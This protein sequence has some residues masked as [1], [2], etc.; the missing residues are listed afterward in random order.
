MLTFI[1]MSQTS[2]KA[3][4][5]VGN[6]EKRRDVGG[7]DDLSMAIERLG[8]CRSI[9]NDQFWMANSQLTPAASESLRNGFLSKGRWQYRK[10]FCSD[11]KGICEATL[12]GYRAHR[13]MPKTNWRQITA[14]IAPNSSLKKSA[15]ANRQAPESAHI[16]GPKKAFLWAARPL[17]LCCFGHVAASEEEGFWPALLCGVAR[18]AALAASAPG[19]DAEGAPPPVPREFRGFGLPLSI[20]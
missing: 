2:R 15:H 19:A 5:G 20:I 13:N 1:E 18:C 10:L 11:P 6:R 3:L 9:P 17:L 12:N 16:H 4:P 14:K 8:R 7:F